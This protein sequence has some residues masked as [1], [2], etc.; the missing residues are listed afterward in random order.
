MKHAL[1]MMLVLLVGC[2]DG[3]VTP[4]ETEG[5][6]I[7]IEVSK[8]ENLVRICVV[9]FRDTLRIMECA[10]DNNPLPIPIPSLPH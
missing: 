9:E 3:A 7:K 10:S 4:T 6:S 5:D 8:S 1:V 2:S